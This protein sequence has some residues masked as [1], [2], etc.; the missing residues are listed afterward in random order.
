M[1]YYLPIFPPSPLVSTISQE[2]GHPPVRRHKDASNFALIR[3]D[4]EPADLSGLR[5]G[6]HHHIITE[7]AI[8]AHIDRRGRD[9]GLNPEQPAGI[10]INAVDDP[11][12]SPKIVE[13]W[14]GSPQSAKISHA[15]VGSV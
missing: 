12:L 4:Q 9:V 5:I 6:S 2:R 8:G 3:P 11:Y 10:Q 1:R 13:P 7:S 15:K 14:A